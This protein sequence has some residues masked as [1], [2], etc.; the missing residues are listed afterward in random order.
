MGTFS[1]SIAHFPTLVVTVGYIV[2]WMEM[3]FLSCGRPQTSPAAPILSLVFGVAIVVHRFRYHRL[4][5]KIDDLVLLYRVLVH[6]ELENS[7]FIISYN[8]KRKGSALRCHFI[9][10]FKAWTGRLESCWKVGESRLTR[11]PPAA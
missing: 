5:S 8:R 11:L 1:M 6:R 3:Y 10:F 7:S 9:G 4:K 2:F